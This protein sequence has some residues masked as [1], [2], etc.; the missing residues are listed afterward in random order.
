MN[1]NGRISISLRN[2]QVFLNS[3][4]YV[5]YGIIT[6]LTIDSNVHVIL[7]VYNQKKIGKGIPLANNAFNEPSAPE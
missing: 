3:E 7:I 2:R 4:E 1:S 6:F 5:G